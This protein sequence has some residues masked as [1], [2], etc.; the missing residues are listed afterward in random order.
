VVTPILRSGGY[1]LQDSPEYQ[2]SG[3]FTI[4]AGDDF[5]GYELSYYAVRRN[6]DGVRV[7]FDSA[8]E[9]RGDAKVS[10]DN[11]ILCLFQIPTSAKHIRLIYLVRV[12]AADHNMAI[13]A[14]ERTD[15]LDELTQRVRD[16]PASCETHEGTY[17]SWVP[18]GIAVR[19]ETRPAS[20]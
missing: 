14:A 10:K 13:A 20:E 3:A 18:A 8:E 2:D 19:P 5:V 11:P 15:K 16:N 9:I 4:E 17:C 7:E 6:A 1:Q 12:S